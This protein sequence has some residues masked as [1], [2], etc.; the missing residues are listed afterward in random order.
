MRLTYRYDGKDGRKAEVLTEAGQ[1]LSVKRIEFVHEA[2]KEP[3]VILDMLQMPIEIVN[4]KA[5]FRVMHPT[6]GVLKPVK[7]IEFADGTTWEG[8]Q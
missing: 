3:V 2:G 5:V 4:A 7:R 1:S 6:D 8:A